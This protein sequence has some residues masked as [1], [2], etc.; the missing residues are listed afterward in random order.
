MNSYL[1]TGEP[2]IP[3]PAYIQEHNHMTQKMTRPIHGGNSWA[4]NSYLETGEPA[5]HD[6]AYI[7]EHEHTYPE[8]DTSNSMAATHGL[9]TATWKQVSPPSPTPHTYKNTYTRIPKTS[10]PIPWRQLMGCEQ[11]P[12]NR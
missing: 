2:A 4:A 1:K 6:P 12:G 5:I 8:N 3:D 7:Q 10:R 11:L 9:R